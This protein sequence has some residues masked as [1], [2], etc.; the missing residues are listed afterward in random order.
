MEE[1]V[2][3]VIENYDEKS[4]VENPPEGIFMEYRKYYGNGSGVSVCGQFDDD[5]KF[6][7][8]YYYPFFR[9][10]TVTTQEKVTIERHTDK[11]SY[12]GAC[13]DLRIG[14][15]MIFYLQNP[16]EYMLEQKKGTLAVGNPPLTLSGLAREGKILFPVQKDKEAV[17]VDRE[18]TNNR[19]HLLA[20]AR[21]GDEEAMENLTMEDM[22][23]YSMISQR[24][25]TE[26]VLSIVDSYFMPYGIECDQYNVLGEILDFRISHNQLTG[27]ELVQMT[28]E[29]NDMQYDVCVNRV[30]LLGE[31]AVGRRFKGTIWLQGQLHY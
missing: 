5:Q 12:A 1:I 15:T 11:Q 13:D 7:V 20:A 9:G 28:V 3:D 16:A 19:N 27:E 8:E 2:Y 23:I 14:I 31:P 25:A 21:N 22:D 30:D 4:A 26:D 17:K 18:I 29:S 6:H 10:N 24:I